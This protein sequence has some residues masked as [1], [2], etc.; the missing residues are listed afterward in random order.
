MAVSHPPAVAIAIDAADVVF[1]YLDGYPREL[2]VL[3]QLLHAVG[4]VG[5]HHERVAGLAA[6]HYHVRLFALYEPARG[7]FVSKQVLL[8][9]NLSHKKINNGLDPID[10]GIC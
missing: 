8:L 2:F 4:D 1:S 7:V 9:K 3:D 6:D 10:E 5:L